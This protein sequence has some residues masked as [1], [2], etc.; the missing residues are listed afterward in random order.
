MNPA[1]Q[2]GASG[3]LGGSLTIVLS[4]LLS[5]AHVTVPDNVAIA[6]GVILTTA[7]SYGIHRRTVAGVLA[8]AAA[9]LAGATEPATPAAPTA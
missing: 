2:A 1:M 7:I 6:M 8:A 3:G 9:D 5:L 4:W